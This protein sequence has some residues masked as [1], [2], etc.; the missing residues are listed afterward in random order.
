M[1]GRSARAWLPAVAEQGPVPQDLWRGQGQA[2]PLPSC[3][4]L[5]AVFWS[6]ISAMDGLSWGLSTSLGRTLRGLV[7]TVSQIMRRLSR[8][9]G[10]IAEPH[11]IAD[12]TGN[13]VSVGSSW[14]APASIA[15]VV[16]PVLQA[17]I[18]VSAPTATMAPPRANAIV[19]TPNRSAILST[20]QPGKQRS[21][22][23]PASVS[24]GRCARRARLP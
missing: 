6:E 15:T 4:W 21:E 17:A 9:D 16:S 10:C 13:A 20:T 2:G 14:R 24:F 1:C 11:S 19:P 5:R 8:P 12:K 7:I 23:D 22:L 18:P 3:L